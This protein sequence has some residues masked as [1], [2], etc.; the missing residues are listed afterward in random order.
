MT[1]RLFLVLAAVAALVGASSPASAQGMRV[2]VR[3]GASVDPDQFYFGGHV[4]TPAI[5]D[6]I[7]LRPNLEIGVGDDQTLIGVNIEAIYKYPLRRS[8]WVVYGGGGPA[9][10]YYDFDNDDSDTRGGLN[11]VGG[12]E[13]DL[14]ELHVVLVHRAIAQRDPGNAALARV[15][16]RRLPVPLPVPVALVYQAGVARVVLR[17]RINVVRAP[18]AARHHVRREALEA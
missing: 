9:I 12:L 8:L 6:R 7:H 15:I 5:V 2:G 18:G 10:N 3:A 1:K 14:F 16:L 13:H 4:E 17:N 11:F